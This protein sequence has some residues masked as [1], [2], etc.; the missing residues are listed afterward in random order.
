MSKPSTYPITYEDCKSIEIKLL[1]E[2]QRE[3]HRFFDD[4][5]HRLDEFR[6]KH[7]E[8]NFEMQHRFKALESDVLTKLEMIQ[9][10]IQMQIESQQK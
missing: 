4:Q 3:M 10:R 5:S 7:E 6:R 1:N 2:Q 8:M 9:M